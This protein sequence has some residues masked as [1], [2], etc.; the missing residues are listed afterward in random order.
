MPDNRSGTKTGA[1][2]KKNTHA[3]NDDGG[4]EGEEYTNQGE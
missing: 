1:K 3:D 4:S 2:A